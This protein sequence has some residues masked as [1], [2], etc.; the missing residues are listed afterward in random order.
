MKNL[1]LKGEVVVT[2]GYVVEENDG[3][4]LGYKRTRTGNSTPVV[5][6]T[7][8]TCFSNVATVYPVSFGFTAN[9]FYLSDPHLPPPP[10]LSLSYIAIARL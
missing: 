5:V 8:H 4:E 6:P 10:S 9:Y 2:S 3:Y 1:P 7:S